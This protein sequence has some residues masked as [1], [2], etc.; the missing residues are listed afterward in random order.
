[1]TNLKFRSNL[2]PIKIIVLLFIT[3]SITAKET[4]TPEY[5]LHVKQ[6]SKPFIAEMEK[7]YDLICIGTGGGLSR[8]V[9]KIDIVFV[10]YRKSTIEESRKIIVSGVQTLVN[11]LNTH[12]KI[13]PFLAQH[14]FQ[15]NNIGISIS[16]RNRKENHYTDGSVALVF[17]AKNKIFYQA[18]TMMT[19]MSGGFSDLR[20]PKN[21]IHYPLKEETD[22]ELIDLDEESFEEAVKIVEAQSKK[23]D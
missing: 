7:K 9:E 5:L 21:P 8:N 1:M 17:N 6:I 18:A 19:R 23:S 3:T 20:N 16:F 12:E 2:C 15:P 10:A 22:L 13:R 4:P 14:P 11:E